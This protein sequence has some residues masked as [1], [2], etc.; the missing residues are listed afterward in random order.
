IVFPKER[1]VSATTSIEPGPAVAIKADQLVDAMDGLR[2]GL[3][4]FEANGLIRYANDHFRYLHRTFEKGVDVIGRRFPDLIKERVISCEFLGEGAP[5]TGEAWIKERARRITNNDWRPLELKLDDGRWIELKERPAPCGG[6]I[7]LWTDITELR[8]AHLRLED[9]MSATADAFAYWSPHDEL[10]SFNAS[11]AALTPLARARTDQRRVG[12]WEWVGHAEATGE[13]SFQ[14]GAVPSL[15]EHED[16]AAKSFARH[17]DGRVF[18]LKQRRARDGGRVAVF[19]DVSE[20]AA[21]RLSTVSVGPDRDKGSDARTAGRAPSAHDHAF[22]AE[23]ALANADLLR[24]IGCELRS[25]LGSIIGFAEI[26]EA[27]ALGPKGAPA[28][29]DH[30]RTIRKASNRLLKFVDR[31]LELAKIE[32]GAYPFEPEA[33]NVRDLVQDCMRRFADAAT[34]A[35]IRFSADLSEAPETAWCDAA[36]VGSMLDNLVANAL[37]AAAGGAVT[38]AARTDGDDL[39]LSVAD[40]GVGM[41]PDDVR[42]V[43]QPLRQAASANSAA[44]V[45]AGLGLAITRALAGLHGGALMISSKLGEGAT[46]RITLPDASAGE[47][48][49]AE[50]RHG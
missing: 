32:A 8:L 38:V 48:P 26:I 10:R 44:N 13:L 46:A 35:Q 16:A 33:E 2:V 6:W 4:L 9:A 14:D 5:V 45:G 25:S 24:S 28:Y 11:F 21:P 20:F 34:Q 23:T 29:G 15:A 27:E 42:S 12:F 49:S 30:A 47:Q 3:T 36:A 1:A 50:R 18:V 19:S 43:S 37:H 31:A 39:V 7:G 17:R 41:S 22:P 40:T